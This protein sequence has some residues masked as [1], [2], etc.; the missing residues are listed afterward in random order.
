MDVMIDTCTHRNLVVTW[1]TVTIRHAHDATSHISAFLF[2]SHLRIWFF[3][4]VPPPK[5]LT[6]YNW[7]ILDAPIIVLIR[8]KSHVCILCLVICDS[9]NTE[10]NKIGIT[11]ITFLHFLQ[12]SC[13]WMSCK[14]LHNRLYL[15]HYFRL[16]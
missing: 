12:I 6:W 10:N 16:M 1:Y 15:L 13:N 14:L 2:N 3:F 11:Y 7:N 9:I 8:N 4:I 5:I